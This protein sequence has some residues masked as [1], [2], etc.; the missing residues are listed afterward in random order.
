MLK[1]VSALVAFALIAG[2]STNRMPELSRYDA[3]FQPWSSAESVNAVSFIRSGAPGS[4]PLCVALVVSNSGETLSD[5]SNSF[6]GAYTGNYYSLEKSVQV[7]GGNVLQYVAPDNNSLVAEGAVRY[8]VSSL[9]TRSVRYKLSASQLDGG[10][11]YVF[12]DL[13]QAQINSGAASNTGYG[14]VG[15]WSGANP[16]LALQSLER[17]ADEIERCLAQQ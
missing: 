5:S 2:C 8:E 4:L 1:K 3:K 6:F 9:V 17:V 12:S 11:S 14:P 15:S 16:D 10:R 13:A 7:G